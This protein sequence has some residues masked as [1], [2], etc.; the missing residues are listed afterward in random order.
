MPQAKADVQ[1]AQ[2][3]VDAVNADIQQ[4]SSDL[5]KA[6][7]ADPKNQAE[8]TRLTDLLKKQ[9]EDLNAAKKALEDA[10]KAERDIVGSIEDLKD[11]QNSSAK[12]EAAVQKTLAES[13]K[14]YLAS[15]NDAMKALGQAMIDAVVTTTPDLKVNVTANGKPFGDHVRDLMRQAG[16]SELP[17]NAQIGVDDAGNIIAMETF[18]TF[19]GT[20]MNDQ[21]DESQKGALK[22]YIAANM[23]D[24]V[25]ELNQVI[26]ANGGWVDGSTAGM[27]LA[28]SG[29]HIVQ[30]AKDN[31][32]SVTV[33]SGT[34]V[35]READKYFNG[36]AVVD[37]P[38]A[39]DDA[40]RAKMYVFDS[41][42]ERR[43][44]RLQTILERLDT[45]NQVFA[46]DTATAAALKNPNTWQKVDGDEDHEAFYDGDQNLYYQSADGLGIPKG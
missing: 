5:S 2:N 36:S 13:G 9:Q 27:E 24:R 22:E 41:K 3:K 33:I 26:D 1:A 4:T 45:D 21:V 34:G 43:E 32:T 28:Y 23:P 19:L 42:G 18:T 8:I 6:N 37:V 10:K 38:E 20:E 14:V 46:E 44:W 40:K 11:M 17:T 25:E 35:T 15:P 31:P 16:V 7:A 39:G 30:Q 29:G 12:V